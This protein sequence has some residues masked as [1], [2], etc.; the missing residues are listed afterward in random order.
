LFANRDF[1]DSW[2]SE[3]VDDDEAALAEIETEDEE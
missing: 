3:G 2:T 1:S